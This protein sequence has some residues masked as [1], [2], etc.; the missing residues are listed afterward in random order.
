MFATHFGA[1]TIVD[2]RLIGRDWT[3]VGLPCEGCGRKSACGL[4]V[5]VWNY[6]VT[7]LGNDRPRYRFAEIVRREILGQAEHAFMNFA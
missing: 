5:L 4:P 7:T 1:S 6:R 2:E 3:T